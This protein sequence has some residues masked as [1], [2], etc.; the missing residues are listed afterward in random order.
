[1]LA[2]QALAATLIAT[3]ACPAW[4]YPGIVGTAVFSQS[5]TVR[6]N[7]LPA[8]S[9]VFSGDTIE[10]GSS[11]N[12]AVAVSGGTQV[13]V[14]PQ[15]QVRFTR[16]SDRAL[17]E[18]GRGSAA[19]RLG[20][21]DGFEARLADASIRGTGKGPAVGVIVFRDSRTAVIASEKGELNVRTGHDA[22]SVTLRE[23]EGVEVSLAP[24]PA[25]Q[26]GT[27]SAT[28]LSGKKIAIMGIILGG[29]MI[30]VAV[31]L[32]GGDKLSDQEKRNAVS[33]FRFP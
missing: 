18:I 10:V 13:R 4:A 11:G 5:A 30:A 7:T 21:N 3:L 16:A 15:S 8:G 20:E 31:Y 25:P 12:L 28:T 32:I 19:F 23:G 14:G 17:F 9:T 33:P 29:A 26:A 27:T 22:K 24:E 6:G 1:M 2:R